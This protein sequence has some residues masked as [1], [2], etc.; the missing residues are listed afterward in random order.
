[1]TQ[2]CYQVII[3]LTIKSKTAAAKKRCSLRFL[4]NSVFTE[5]S[6]PTFKV[7]GLQMTMNLALG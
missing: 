3:I 5:S 6:P 1:M 7:Q 2:G 4:L